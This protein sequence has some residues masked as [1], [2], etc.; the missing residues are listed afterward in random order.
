MSLEVDE[1]L[2]PIDT[3]EPLN[4]GVKVTP[5][6]S[7]TLD[8]GTIYQGE[9]DSN[10]KPHGRG[11]EERPDG[12]KVQGYYRK[13]LVE[14]LGRALFSDGTMFQGNFKHGNPSGL[15]SFI[16]RNKSKYQGLFREGKLIGKGKKIN[17]DGSVY[18]G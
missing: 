12:T 5:K 14:G 8:D 13:G 7:V 4:D 1:L 9:W 11:M 18:E 2:E 15:G 6:P 17:P 10:E 3:S 16:D